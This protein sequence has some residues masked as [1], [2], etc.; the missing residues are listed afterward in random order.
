[1]SLS[2]FSRGEKRKKLMLT[3]ECAEGDNM[4]FSEGE[5]C[6]PDYVLAEGFKIV[7][8]FRVSAWRFR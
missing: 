3:E 1:M 5:F 4:F 2:D 6:V 7:D 8:R